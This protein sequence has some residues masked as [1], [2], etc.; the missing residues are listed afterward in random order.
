MEQFKLKY[1]TWAARSNPQAL[2]ELKK[3]QLENRTREQLGGLDQAELFKPIAKSAEETKTLPM[4]QTA[5]RNAR[6]AATEGKM[7]TGTSGEIDL[8]LKKLLSGV[9]FPT[10]PRI[11]ATEEFKAYIKPILAAARQSLVGGAN[12]SDSDMKIAEAAVGGNITLD[13]NSIV[14]I[15][16]SL[17][18]MNTAM[19]ANHQRKV[20]ALAG[21]DPQRQSVLFGTYGLPMENVVPREAIGLLK[22]QPSPE[23]MQQFDRKYHTPGLAQRILGG[24]G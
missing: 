2:E 16:G 6:Q 3:T 19:A 22:S 15:L 24:G 1:Q 20:E 11:P 21:E 7:F 17:E 4:A 5:I 18:R 13:R 8:S 10:D 12:I 9:G 23:V 14:G